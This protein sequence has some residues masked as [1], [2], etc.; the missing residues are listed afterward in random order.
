LDFG[1]E[2]SV[3]TAHS[4]P[5]GARAARSVMRRPDGRIWIPL[6]KQLRWPPPGRGSSARQAPSQV[7][8]GPYLVTLDF[9]EVGGRLECVRFEIG[10]DMDEPNSPDPVPVTASALRGIPLGELIDQA[11][12]ERTKTLRRWAKEAGPAGGRS[13]RLRDRVASAEASLGRAPGRPPE[14]S[15]DHFKQVA[16]AY[17]RAWKIGGHPTESVATQWHVSP[18][19]AAKWVA[20]AREMG[21]LP[22]TERGRARG[23]Q[24]RGE[25]ARVKPAP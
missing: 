6:R 2:S 22:P 13:R 12:F 5:R 14:Y 9:A 7:P 8:S 15:E 11:L 20:R 10:A 21:F 16:D 3:V 19:A 4:S 1:K 17:T 24:P 25:R 23:G 18:S